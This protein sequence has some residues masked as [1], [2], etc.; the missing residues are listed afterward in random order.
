MNKPH[1]SRRKFITGCLGFGAAG[2]SSLVF[3]GSCNNQATAPADKKEAQ[4]ANTGT[5]E[6]CRDFTGV[7]EEELEKRKKMG[8]VEKSQVAES[9]CS[10]CGLYLPQGEDQ[11]CGKCLLFKGPV[12]A[13]GHCVQWVAKTHN[14]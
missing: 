13:E 5:M 6:P 7:S 3:L 1:H 9:S 12:F 11:A 4:P 14:G 8:Y 2:L 10:N